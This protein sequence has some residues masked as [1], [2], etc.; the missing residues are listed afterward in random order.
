MIHIL[1]GIR[2]FSAYFVAPRQVCLIGRTRSYEQPKEPQIEAQRLCFI[3]RRAGVSA[4]DALAADQ[5]APGEYGDGASWARGFQPRQRA[6]AI[7][8]CASLPR[9]L[10]ERVVSQVALALLSLTSVEGSGGDTWNGGGE[11]GAGHP[12]AHCMKTVA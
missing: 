8:N 3:S 9:D 2:S 6:E 4:K 1:G 7:R 5:P 11:R 10:V 12:T